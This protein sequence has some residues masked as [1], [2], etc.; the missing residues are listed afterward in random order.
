[1]QDGLSQSNEIKSLP[2]A[3]LVQVNFDTERTIAD[4][5]FSKQQPM[6]VG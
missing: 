1:L 4:E 2:E 6:Q 5:F 3:G